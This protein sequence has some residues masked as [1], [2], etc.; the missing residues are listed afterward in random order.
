MIQELRTTIMSLR[1]ENLRLVN[2]VDSLLSGKSITLD[3]NINSSSS[4]SLSPASSSGSSSVNF[5]NN[6]SNSNNSREKLL[7]SIYNNN[8]TSYNNNNNNNN[9]SSK[10][11]RSSPRLNYNNNTNDMKSSANIFN[12]NNPNTNTDM[13]S[14]DVMNMSTEEM[15]FPELAALETEFQRNLSIARGEMVLPGPEEDG[16]NNDNH[17]SDDENGFG[18]GASFGQV[19]IMNGGEE[20]L[21]STKDNVLTMSNSNSGKNSGKTGKEVPGE[22]KEV[23]KADPLA[24]KWANKNKWFGTD[25]LMTS[26]AY[27]THDE[28]MKRGVNPN[29]KEYYEL[30]NKAVIERFPSKKNMVWTD[31]SSASSKHNSNKSKLSSKGNGKSDSHKSH[32]SSKK[33]NEQRLSNE[34]RLMNPKYTKHLPK[35][36]PTSN[37][38][39]YKPLSFT[40][41]NSSFTQHHHLS[42][43][44]SDSVSPTSSN[45]HFVNNSNDRISMNLDNNSSSSTSIDNITRGISYNSPK[46]ESINNNNAN[47]VHNSN[48][49]GASTS[50]RESADCSYTNNNTSAIISNNNNSLVNSN[51]TNN[52]SKSLRSSS[53]LSLSS[54]YSYSSSKTNTVKKQTKANNSLFTNAKAW[55]SSTS[56]GMPGMIINNARKRNSFDIHR[57]NG[58]ELD[59]NSNGHHHGINNDSNNQSL[60][61]MVLDRESFIDRREK[62]LS[63]LQDARRAA[64]EE[65]RAIL[66]KLTAIIR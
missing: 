58:Y 8:N 12:N 18:E 56:A 31:M 49:F 40:D 27:D 16:N 33:D 4:A 50:P 61:I 45:H 5:G 47:K 20:V 19:E 41:K 28:L 59:Y 62:I 48:T 52:K 24:T 39:I 46:D 11:L 13:S 30:L 23:M 36:T 14:T 21:M 43:T 26:F 44:R 34:L 15:M 60:P 51:V 9:N 65:H 63:E 17:H 1:Q 10:S 2:Q 6:D 54:T 55:D 29:S 57:K 22:E 38:S 37:N 3:N 7:L 42:I 25:H 53:S 64:E 32:K 66:D 35:C